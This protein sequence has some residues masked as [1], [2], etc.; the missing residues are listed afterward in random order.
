MNNKKPA[1][2]SF[3]HGCI[4]LILYFGVNIKKQKF[5]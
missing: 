2:C 3:I 1:I 4:Y 5:N